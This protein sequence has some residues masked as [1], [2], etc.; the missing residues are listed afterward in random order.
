MRATPITAAR[1]ASSAVFAAPRA[2]K[3]ASARRASG[4]ALLGSSSSR[5]SSAIVGRRSSSKSI[6]PAPRALD[7]D[8]SDPDTIV[9]ALGGVL[10][11]V[12]GIGAPLF[13]ISRDK[14]DEGAF[15]LR[16]EKVVIVFFV[17]VLFFAM[18]SNAA[19][20]QRG[21]PRAGVSRVDV[22]PSLDCAPVVF[23]GM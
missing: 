14:K 16:V 21:A 10:G 1:G 19:S 6:L 12:V 13:Y 2:S 9:G 22:F 18:R 3:T 7:I 11:I 4:A 5:T 17:F 15:F 23:L 8:W 20:E